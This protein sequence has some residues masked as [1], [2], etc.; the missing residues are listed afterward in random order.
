MLRFVASMRHI[1]PRSL[2][3]VEEQER[4]EEWL[5]KVL[6][7]ARREPDL[8]L[9]LV[10]CQR[11]IKGYGDT[12]ERGLGNFRLI[13]GYVADGPIGAGEVAKLREAALADDRT[14]EKTSELQSLK[15]KSYAV[16]C[17]EKKKRRKQKISN[18]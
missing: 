2:R 16:L 3:Y 10:R 1:R 9:E 11:L 17:M 8:A 5:R 6:Q 12:F 7:Y 18:D 4:I 15:R 14:E 13:M